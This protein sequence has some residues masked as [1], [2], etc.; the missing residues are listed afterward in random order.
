[1]EALFSGIDA[2][3]ELAEGAGNEVAA[4]SEFG[5]RAHLRLA[6]THTCLLVDLLYLSG[7]ELEC[8]KGLT[9]KYEHVCAVELDAGNG[10]RLHELRIC[11]L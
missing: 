7:I 9:T 8:L 2:V 6:C 10:L 1:M 3:D 4:V 5:F 11:Y